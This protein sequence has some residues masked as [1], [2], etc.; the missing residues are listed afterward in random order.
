MGRVQLP[1]SWQ[2]M[3]KP[4][5][6]FASLKPVRQVKFT[7]WPTLVFVL[8]GVLKAT[9]GRKSQCPGENKQ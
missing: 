2:V 5:S 3:L 4:V 6:L 7:T 1:F 8:S 9:S